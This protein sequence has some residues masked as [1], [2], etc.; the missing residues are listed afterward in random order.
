MAIKLNDRRR[1]RSAKRASRQ[2]NASSRRIRG[3][4]G[5][6]I[7][8]MTVSMALI[9]LL[10]AAFIATCTV[11]TNLQA[12]ASN[13]AQACT[14][15]SEFVAAYGRAEGENETAFFTSYH[16][17]LSLSL[18]I[19]IDFT[20]SDGEIIVGGEPIGDSGAGFAADGITFQA[21]KNADGSVSYKYSTS[22]VR[23]EATA[24]YAG[25]ITA[26]GYVN[27]YTSAVCSYTGGEVSA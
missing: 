14:A 6:T 15:A 2:N 22:Q 5:F 17:Q 8:E 9:A 11:S 26:K 23:V 4:R 1:A 21:E 12:R 20:V 19:T 3:K 27:G 13:A 16:G 10:T 24:T 18:G 25:G 7:V